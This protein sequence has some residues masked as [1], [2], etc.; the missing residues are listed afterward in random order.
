MAP[1]AVQ[2]RAGG[3]LDSLLVKE[4]HVITHGA[5]EGEYVLKERRTD[6][7]VVL[8]PADPYPAVT[9]SYPGETASDADIAALEREHGAFLPPDGEG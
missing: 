8:I 9:P 2:P 1:P 4:E 6:G 7:S 5:I 3:A